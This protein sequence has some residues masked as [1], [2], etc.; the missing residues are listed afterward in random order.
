MLPI[1]ATF[2]SNMLQESILGTGGTDEAVIDLLGA[3]YAS[4]KTLIAKNATAVNNI[5]VEILE[6]DESGSGFTLIAGG[7]VS[8][9]Y[10]TAQKVVRFEWNA[11]NAFKRYAK[12]RITT[13]AHAD[14]TADV[15][16][17]AAVGRGNVDPA[18]TSELA[19]STVILA[20]A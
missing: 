18:A 14:D 12:I 13:G 6:S 1:Q 8:I 4:F 3:N 9:E 17:L 5:L 16:V 2:D 10:I 19:D 7:S 15:A 20:A 11:V